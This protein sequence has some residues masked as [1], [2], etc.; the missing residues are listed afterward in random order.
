MDYGIIAFTL[1][2]QI[3]LNLIFCSMTN[4]KFKFTLTYLIDLSIVSCMI[5]WFYR[6]DV[7]KSV[8]NDGMGLEA[9]PTES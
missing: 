2:L 4:R 3:I 5:V 1:P 7:N 9:V 6:Y 8:N